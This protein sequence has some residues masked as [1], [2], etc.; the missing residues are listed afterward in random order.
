MKEP[1]KCRCGSKARVRNKGGFYWVE[2]TNKKCKKKSGFLSDGFGIVSKEV[3]EEQVVK[4]W[5]SALKSSQNGN[6]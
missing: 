2:C 3:A 1:M 5:N 6:T 4:I